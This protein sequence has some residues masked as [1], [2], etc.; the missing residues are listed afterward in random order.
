MNTIAKVSIVAGAILLLPRILT[1]VKKAENIKDNIYVSTQ[2]KGVKP[3]I[4]TMGISLDAIIRN[5]S[6]FNINLR[7]LL[8]RVY[9]VDEKGVRTEL[10]VTGITREVAL[11]NNQESSMPVTLTISNT[12]LPGLLKAAKVEVIT[13]YEVAGIQLNYPSTIDIKELKDKVLSKIGLSGVENSL[14]CII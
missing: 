5:I 3:G 12:R 7:N 13:W 9:M 8:T 6:G 1:G 4:F 2:I 11:T 10:G 14:T